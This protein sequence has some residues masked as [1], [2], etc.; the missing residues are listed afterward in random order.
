[1][2]LLAGTGTDGA[3]YACSATELNDL[4]SVVLGLGIDFAAELVDARQLGVER[5]ARV[6]AGGCE[7]SERHGAA[8]ERELE[9]RPTRHAQAVAE[10][11][12]R[13]P[14][15]AAGV[16][17]AT[18]EGVGE[19]AP[20]PQHLARFFDRVQQRRL[21]RGQRFEL[22]NSAHGAS[23]IRVVPQRN[24]LIWGASGSEAT[25][26]TQRTP[27]DKSGHISTTAVT[28][29]TPVLVAARTRTSR[30]TPTTRGR[31]QVGVSFRI[32]QSG[33]LARDPRAK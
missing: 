29:F 4:R 11:D 19:R 20:D 1:M 2:E 8:V 18:S 26:G 12:H 24:G 16:L 22:P 9:Q 27:A 23:Y 25:S 14:V 30:W 3:T 5:A 28:S 32:P 13:E 10:A 31:A 7:L 17:V 21:V 6:V 15:E 33:T